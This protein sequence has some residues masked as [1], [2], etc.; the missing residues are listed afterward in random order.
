[1]ILATAGWGTWWLS[2]LALR[3]APEIF[4][5]ETLVYSVTCTLAAIGTFLAIFSIRARLIWVLLAAVPICSNVSLLLM[6]TILDLD[7]L[8]LLQAETVD[9]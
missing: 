9:P 4:P 7:R 2:L 6:P 3:F 1:M 8:A 5:G